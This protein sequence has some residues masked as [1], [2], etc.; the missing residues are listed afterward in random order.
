MAKIRNKAPWALTVPG[1]G[2]VEPDAVVEVRD[3]DVYSHTA[4]ANW[5]PVDKAAT[6]A[7]NAGAKAEAEAVKAA[8]GVV[9]EDPVEAP[10]EDG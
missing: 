8:S 6:T 5:E 1:Y 9:D 3:A 7:H 4:S 10:A 2:V